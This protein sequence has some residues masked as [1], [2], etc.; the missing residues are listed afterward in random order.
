M[1]FT[2]PRGASNQL[3]STLS[4][5]RG[6][7]SP[8]LPLVAKSHLWNVTGAVSSENHLSVL[9]S[10]ASYRDPTPQSQGS[11]AQCLYRVREQLEA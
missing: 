4:Q 8:L 7:K 10:G 11:E 6:R 3:A 5:H 9:Y 1:Y 2:L